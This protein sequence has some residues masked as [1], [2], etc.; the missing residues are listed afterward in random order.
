MIP[1]KRV[2]PIL[3]WAP[4][5]LKAE[6]VSDF[7][8]AVI[9]TIMLAPQSLVDLAA[10][11]R[12]FVC[13]KADFAA[14]AT[15]I[16]LVLLVGVEAGIVAGVAL[17]LL[18]FLWR[19]SRPHMAIVGQ[20]PGTEHF[21]NVKRHKVITHPELLTIRV[22]ESLYFANARFLKIT[23]ARTRDGDDG[24]VHLLRKHPE[25]SSPARQALPRLPPT[26]AYWCSWHSS[27]VRVSH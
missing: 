10:I 18:M 13:S 19:T 21:R 7:V 14:M 22:D 1:L 2:L 9:V 8:A 17:S 15:T 24:N 4:S 23:T 12:T 20:I 27:L 3:G 5:Y 11:K 25:V 16:V 26:R 6:A